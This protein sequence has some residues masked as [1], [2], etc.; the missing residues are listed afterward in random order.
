MRST[1]T[2][3][4]AWDQYRNSLTPE[5]EAYKVMRVF[6]VH[7]KPLAYHQICDLTKE[8]FP[9]SP[10]EL[11][12]MGSTVRRKLYMSQRFVFPVI[13]MFELTPKKRKAQVWVSKLFLDQNPNFRAVEND[14]RNTTKQGKLPFDNPFPPIND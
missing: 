1:K 6:E 4:W 8:L 5:K 2:Q 7:N 13:D 10:V 11:N 9:E 3:L 12:H 14:P